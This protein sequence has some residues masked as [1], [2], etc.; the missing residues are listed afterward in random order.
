MEKKSQKYGAVREISPTHS[1]TFDVCSAPDKENILNVFPELRNV[2]EFNLPCGD[3]EFKNKLIKFIVLLYSEDSI[4]NQKP[5]IEIDERK[6]RAA[7]LAGFQRHANNRFSDEVEDA[8]FALNDENVLTLVLG[9]LKFQNKILWTEIITTEQQW[10]ENIQ[11]RIKGVRLEAGEDYDKMYKTAS[12]YKVNLRK[13]GKSIKD[14]LLEMYKDFYGDHDDLREK[15]NQTEKRANLE[16][17]A[18]SS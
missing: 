9:Y 6:R 2:Y 14:D 15:M 12:Y 16:S 4:L 5:P 3:N 1:M 17:Y 8:V 10:W 7:Y 13:E 18:S 11:L